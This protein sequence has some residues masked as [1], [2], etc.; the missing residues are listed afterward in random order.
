MH[1]IFLP[2]YLVTPGVLDYYVTSKILESIG[3]VISPV[4][5]YLFPPMLHVATNMN[6]EE[7]LKSCSKARCSNLYM[8]T[9]RKATLQQRIF[10]FSKKIQ[11]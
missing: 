6:L 5:P 11:I 8:G 10:G 4:F 7:A 3:V 2:L 9:A 1:C